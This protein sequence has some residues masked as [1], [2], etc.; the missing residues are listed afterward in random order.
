MKLFR[1]LLIG[2]GVLAALLAVILILALVPSVQTWAA[3]RVIA[4]DPS[5]GV[6]RLGR[7]SAGFN[8]IDISDVTFVRPGLALT[9]P[10]VSIELP[11]VAAVS[12][13]IQLRRVTAKGW[14]LDL[15]PGNAGSSVPASAPSAE[16]PVDFEGVFELLALPVD[17]AVGP[18][19]IEGVV[20]FPTKAGEPPGRAHVKIT[21]GDLAV[22]REG[23]FTISAEATLADG[24]APVNRL[25]AESTL[26]LRMDTPRTFTRV[27][28][29]TDFRAVGPG[30]PQGAHLL[31]ESAASREGDRESYELLIKSKAGGVEKKLVELSVSNPSGQKPF[32]GTWKLDANDADVAPFTLGR[33]LPQFILG[34]SGTFEADQQFREVR[35]IGKTHLKADR[36]DALYIGLSTLGTI[37]VQTEFDLAR[38]STGIRVNQFTLDV[39]SKSPVMSVRVLQAME[40]VPATRE[41]KVASPAADFFRV[42]LKGAPLAWARPFAPAD[43]TLTG[44]D[45]RG[46]FI[47]RADQGGFAVR[48][49]SPLLL[50]NLTVVQA[51]KT[52]AN[53]LD[54]SIAVTASHAPAGWQ[55]DV[56]ELMARSG[57]VPLLTL[58]A[59]AGQST[60]NKQPIKV[61][62]RFHA[63]L[64]A[65]FS[66]PAVAEFSVFSQGAAEMEFTASISDALQQLSST[67]ALTGLRTRDGQDLPTLSSDLRADRHADGRIE[68]NL[69]LVFELAGRKSDIELAASVKPAGEALALDAQIL[70]RELYVDDLKL[71]TALQPAKPASAPAPKPKPAP[72]QER[73][74]AAPAPD[75]KPVWAGVTGQ[76]KLALKKVVYAAA[77]PPVEISTSVKITPEILTLEALHAVFPD[78]AAAK[79]EGVIKFEASVAAEPYD[80][81]ANVAATNLD[82]QPFLQAAN[83]GHPPTVEGKFDFNGKVT[84]R[85]ASLDKFADTANVDAQLVSRGGQFHGFATSAAAANLGRLQEGASKVGSLLSFAGSVLGKSE[86]ARAGEKAR[87]G[88]DTIE[89]L[90]NFNFDQ[91]NIDISHRAGAAT[92]EIKNFS[93]LSPDM[94]LR[95]GGSIDSKSGLKSILH[96]AM[97]LDLQ[98]A[99][100]GAQADDLRI[101]EL[102]RREADELG[103]TALLDTFSVKGTPSRPDAL[104]LIQQIVAKIR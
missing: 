16:K 56:S 60:A 87:A 99:V 84:G 13:D 32:S 94:R 80:V 59:K 36:L 42:S 53:A 61:T 49:A 62:G 93:I 25:T 90:V 101:L 102:L 29:T 97:N 77:Q 11:L 52:L 12:G 35:L 14:T 2:A 44:D 64:P 8:R 96:S 86:L 19:D 63:E 24:L 83:P 66:Q 4:S 50:E 20:I 37:E 43:L 9:L 6:A 18:S 30:L 38:R 45:V 104:S 70:S 65:I 68:A 28:V 67:L 54:L 51:G 100:R 92:T 73:G 39:S 72:G 78:G 85:A 55:V 91:F 22:G 41:I 75:S 21:G 3:R 10:S 23:R 74:P 48:S 103:Y 79:A 17:L 27:A 34:A 47:A 98:M 69:P 88:S 5:L 1:L 33:A 58:T 71:F 82:P 40:I 26:T 57:G 89:R 15:T 7:V 31:S 46:E 81:S 76:V 95:G